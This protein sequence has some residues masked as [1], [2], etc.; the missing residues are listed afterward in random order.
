MTTATFLI[1]LINEINDIG[2]EIVGDAW[3]WFVTSTYQ[4]EKAQK[5]KDVL[6]KGALQQ[7]RELGI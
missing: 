1:R 2:G 5:S 6:M 7:L 4:Q 3:D